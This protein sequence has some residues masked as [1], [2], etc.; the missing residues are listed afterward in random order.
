[1]HQRDTGSELKGSVTFA[2]CFQWMGRRQENNSSFQ[3][4]TSSEYFKACLS[5][6]F[7]G[8]RQEKKQLFLK[9]KKELGTS[10]ISL[11]VCYLYNGKVC[12]TAKRSNSDLQSIHRYAFI[13]FN[14]FWFQAYKLQI[15]SVWCQNS[16][17]L[18]A[19]ICLF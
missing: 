11:S 16:L 3:A 6:Y 19:V 12:I 10:V 4:L 15:T 8:S 1:M 17:H 2:S 14:C 18:H 9:E 13:H 7:T 5:F